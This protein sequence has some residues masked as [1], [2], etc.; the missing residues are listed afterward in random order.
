M[1]DSSCC[2][3]TSVSLGQV[4]ETPNL[5]KEI[6]WQGFE[7]RAVFRRSC[8]DHNVGKVLGGMPIS[9][10]ALGPRS[11]AM[12]LEGIL[13]SHMG[14]RICRAL[15]SYLYLVYRLLWKFTVGL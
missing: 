9:P 4:G 2:N 11:R 15:M 8:H 12:P 10:S 6:Y 3:T 5:W 1:V 14:F 7:K 13:A